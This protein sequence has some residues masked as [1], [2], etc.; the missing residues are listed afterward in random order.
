M[1]KVICRQQESGIGP[2]SVVTWHS[3]VVG[4]IQ[5]GSRIGRGCSQVSKHLL[6]RLGIIHGL[7]LRLR[8]RS[9]EAQPDHVERLAQRPALGQ[10]VLDLDVVGPH[11]LAGIPHAGDDLL[12]GGLVDKVAET[13]LVRVLELE[14]VVVGE[15]AG[16]REGFQ[17]GSGH[18]G[19]LDELRVGGRAGAFVS[20]CNLDA[21]QASLPLTRRTFMMEGNKSR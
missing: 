5:L 16:E 13:H 11:R 20:F 12:Y 4:G 1:C 18:L 7:L 6:G 3:L 21:W 19:F 15:E 8:P 17:D 14:L 10:I 9:D 2:R